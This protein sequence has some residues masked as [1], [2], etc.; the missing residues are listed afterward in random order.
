M[1]LTTDGI[2]KASFHFT[3]LK[4]Q[5]GDVDNMVSKTDFRDDVLVVTIGPNGKILYN[6]MTCL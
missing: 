3:K 5:P 4:I 2:N 6:V 1:L